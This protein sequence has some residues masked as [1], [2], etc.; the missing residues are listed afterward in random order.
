MGKRWLIAVVGIGVG[1]VLASPS[2]W[3]ADGTTAEAAPADAVVPTEVSNETLTHLRSAIAEETDPELRQTMEEQLQLL[4]SGQLDLTTEMDVAQGAAPPSGEAGAQQTS[5]LADMLTGG[6]LAGQPIDP[7]TGGGGTS[8]E[9]LP[10]QARAEL[11][12]L[13]QEKGTGDPSKDGHV[14]EEA[15]KILERYGIDPREI[16][17]G[18][19]G[20]WQEGG[21]RDGNSDNLDDDT[22]SV[23]DGIGRGGFQNEHDNDSLFRGA[24][25]LERLSPEALEHMAP[26]ARERLERVYGDTSSEGREYESRGFETP[27]REVYG[28]EQTERSEGSVREQG[29]TSA[30]E[31]SSY[32]A[33]E[34]GATQYET[35]EHEY[36]SPPS[37]GAA[38][39]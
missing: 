13:F 35:P 24:D 29:E 31:R 26:E 37:G 28:P 6:R 11:E 22:G 7:G 20:G 30:P 8:G 36:G 32:E 34:H 10:P 38:H 27:T 5:R 33:P 25:A 3:A 4:E 39:W 2:V 21:W 15:E 14:R 19:E 12:K 23:L 1:V 18:R 9:T 17:P 16:G